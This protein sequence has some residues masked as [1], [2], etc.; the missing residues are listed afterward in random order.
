[1][2]LY[3]LATHK[4]TVP[5]YCTF[6]ARAVILL[7]VHSLQFPES[8]ANLMLLKNSASGGIN[9]VISVSTANLVLLQNSA[10]GG[11]S[12]AISVAHFFLKYHQISVKSP[13]LLCSRE[14]RF[15]VSHES[16]MSFTGLF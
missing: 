13:T 6:V 11:I 4:I 8:S 3:N 12:E 2:H 7:D 1:M 5:I 14:Y 10:F 16:V 15:S 9:E